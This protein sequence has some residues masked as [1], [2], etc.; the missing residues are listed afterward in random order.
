MVAHD[1]VEAVQMAP[2]EVIEGHGFI[3]LPLRTF[4]PYRSAAAIA[5]TAPLQ[6]QVCVG[7]LA[8]LD[9]LPGNIQPLAGE[10]FAVYHESATVMHQLLA[11]SSVFAITDDA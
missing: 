4:E 8:M 6:A 2:G 1:L 5:Q 10:R 3:D 9:P 11:C 7:A